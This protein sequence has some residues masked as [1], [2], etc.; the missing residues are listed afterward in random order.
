M[1]VPF[2][3]GKNN[4]GPE[5]RTPLPAC[6]P[7]LNGTTVTALY[8]GARVGGDF[9]DFAEVRGRLVL[10][11][12]DIAGSREGAL[13]IA[14]IVQDRFRA[15]VPELFSSREVNEA[16]ALSALTIELNRTVLEAADGVRCAPAFVASF[17]PELGTLQYVNAGHPPAL[18]RDANGVVLLE[19]NGL[20]LGLFSHATHDAQFCVLLPGAALLVPSKGL[21]EARCKRQEFGIEGIR[22]F[23]AAEKVTDARGLC[24]DLLEVVERS[25]KRGPQNDMTV[26]ALV[27]AAAAA[28]SL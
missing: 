22:E 18:V 19:S 5:L 16:E 11:L 10:A 27:R 6:V 28:A 24:S 17:D 26:L 14:A 15:R 20:P 3:L 8:R 2:L 4:A 9:F 25:M 23:F 1:K 7:T 21:V 12:L 13:H